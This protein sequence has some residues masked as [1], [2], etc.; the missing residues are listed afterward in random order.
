MSSG[1]LEEIADKGICSLESI[2]RFKE[3]ADGLEEGPNRTKILDAELLLKA[4]S[5]RTRIKILL[6]LS[7]GEM[8]VCQLAAV[9]SLKQ[10]AISNSLRLME[11]AGLLKREQR[12][13]WHFYSLSENE[14]IPFILKLVEGR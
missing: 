7:R 14:A 3:M 6:L 5:D 4:V 11:R 9:S 12:G 1:E 8:C 2:E 10:P 13:K